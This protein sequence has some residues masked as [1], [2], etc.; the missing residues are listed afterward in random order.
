LVFDYFHILV[1]LD[2]ESTANNIRNALNDL[3]TLSPNLIEEVVL[4]TTNSGDKV[5]EVKFSARLGKTRS[6]SCFFY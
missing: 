4:N 3:P 1:V 2:F 5:I 6:Y